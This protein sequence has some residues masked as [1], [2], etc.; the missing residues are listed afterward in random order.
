[1]LHSVVLGRMQQARTALAAGRFDAAAEHIAPLL[2]LPEGK[3]NGAGEPSTQALLASV[4]DED[5]RTLWEAQLRL[6]HTRPKSSTAAL[7]RDQLVALYARPLNTL[8]QVPNTAKDI[9]GTPCFVAA[10]GSDEASP[11]KVSIE[12]P[13]VSEADKNAF[14]ANPAKATHFNPVFVAAEM[15][16][17]P[18]YYAASNRQFW[19]LAEKTYRGQPVVYFETVLYELLGNGE[20]A[21]T[22]FV[23]VP[24]L[25][26][27]PH[28]TLKDAVNRS[29]RD[30]LPA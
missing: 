30:W 11:I 4:R 21:N 20:L 28:K 7:T 24:R 26:F 5:E 18:D 6:F 25:V 15:I 2:S 10:P 29:V 9:G 23:E 12:V 1:M 3:P 16:D 19:L 27:N 8:G 17:D 13:H 14:L 22:L